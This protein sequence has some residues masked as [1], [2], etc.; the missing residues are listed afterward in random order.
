MTPSAIPALAAAAR[1]LVSTILDGELTTKRKHGDD[2]E[3]LRKAVDAFYAPTQWVARIY[4]H[5][6]TEPYYILLPGTALEGAAVAFVE[7]MREE[8]ISGRLYTAYC[9]ELEPVGPFS[10]IPRN[11]I[12]CADVIPLAPL[13]RLKDAP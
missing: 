1:N 5:G 12:V 10:A 8:V 13:L 6:R 2:V 7:A 9:D 11:S 4:V 3:A